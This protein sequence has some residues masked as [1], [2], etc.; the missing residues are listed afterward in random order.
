[1]AGAAW[2]DDALR[3]GPPPWLAGVGHVGERSRLHALSGDVLERCRGEGPANCVNRCPLHVD[4]RGQLILTRDGRFGDALQLIRQTLPFPGIAGHLCTH[5]CELHCKRIDEDSAVRI[6]EVERFLAA[7]EEGPPRHLLDIAPTSGFRVAVVGSGPAGLLAAHDLARLGHR[8]TL[9]E[10]A[11]EIGGHLTAGIP[12][13]RVPRDVVERDLT[14]VAALGVAC[15]TGLELGKD[16]TLAELRAR[17]D[18]VILA[19]GHEH[20]ARL[21]TLGLPSRERLATV[22]VDPLTCATELTGVFAAGDL[23]SG[24]SS[25]VEAMALGRRAAQSAHR[26]LIGADPR[27]GR[28]PLQRRGLLWSIE[29]PPEERR[30]RERRPDLLAPQPPLLDPGLAVLEAARC[31]GCH[32]EEC[33]TQCDFLA[34]SC[35]SPRQLAERIE[36]D[37]VGA[38]REVFSCTLCSLCARVCPES[39]DVGAMLLEARRELVRAGA[40]P[41]PQHA[42]TLRALRAGVSRTFTLAVPEPGRR[43]SKRL[44]FTGCA[45][46]GTSPRYTVAA[47]DELRRSYP[48]TGVLM[49]CCGA[50]AR[51]LGMEQAFAQAV[52]GIRAAL[53]EVGGE[54]LIVTCPEC[55]ETLRAGLPDVPVRS[56]WAALGDAWEPPRAR[57]GVVVSVH[58]SCRSRED[59]DT[60]DAVRAVLRAAGAEVEEMEYT[61][62]RGRCCGQGGAMERVAPELARG[63]ARRRAGES[64]RVMVT[65]CSRC[66]AALARQG[67]E[68]VGLVEFLLEPDWRSVARRRPPGSLRSWTNRLRTKLAFRRLKPLVS[69]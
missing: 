45:L 42:P 58:D 15:R 39:L 36:Q 67:R 21:A 52:D 4:V 31:L 62:E 43:R 33:M 56:L 37:L 54:E 10:R 13:W 14:I 49:F 29:A 44:F 41:L 47:Y 1:M 24:P 11:Q 16:V 68:T 60:H 30:A 5:P 17:Y 27:E 35:T 7:H 55:M 38:R 46:P 18:V 22:T 23:V 65:S 3:V 12:P 2:R 34:S 53:E 63:M 48:G 59:S 6:R 26:T 57:D 9:I 19:L 64:A 28:E 25:V 32:C 50:P 66:R 69:E 8:V 61:R 51:V 40:A 20:A